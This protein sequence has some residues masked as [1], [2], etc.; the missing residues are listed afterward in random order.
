M[1]PIQLSLYVV[2]K[3]F[4]QQKERIEMLFKLSEDFRALCSDYLL[5]LMYLKKFKKESVEKK[6][7]VSEYKDI[8]AELESELSHFISET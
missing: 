2:K 7:S 3:Q 5:C 8:S 6:L 1:K 4:P